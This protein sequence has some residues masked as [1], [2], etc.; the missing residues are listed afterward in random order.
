MLP[1]CIAMSC[2]ALG[3]AF[4][5]A[6][7]GDKNEGVL[8]AESLRR[9]IDLDAA[10]NN[11]KVSS[12]PV[13]YFAEWMATG[14]ED[15]F[16]G[17]YDDPNSLSRTAWGHL[18]TPDLVKRVVGMSSY[19]LTWIGAQQAVKERLRYLARQVYLRQQKEL[20]VTHGQEV[21]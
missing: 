10:L 2:Y 1:E 14:K 9:L 8:K 6:D 18:T 5:M 19:D 12:I 16:N 15:P 3:N 11:E 4:F 21:K 17:D 13:H 7:R 20:G